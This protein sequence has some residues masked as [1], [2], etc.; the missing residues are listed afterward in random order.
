MPIIYYGDEIGMGDNPF[1]G[2]R[3]GVR[4]PMLWSADSNASF[5]RAARSLSTCRQCS[6]RC[7]ATAR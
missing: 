1:L 2:G 5:S 6:T 4:T 3:D 7:S